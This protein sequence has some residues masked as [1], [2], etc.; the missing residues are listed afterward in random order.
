MDVTGIMA[1][2]NSRQP[3]AEAASALIDGVQF[4]PGVSKN[5]GVVVAQFINGFDDIQDA[6]AKRFQWKTSSLV[7]GHAA[8]GFQLATLVVSAMLA[9]GVVISTA[10]TD[11]FRHLLDSNSALIA[12]VAGLNVFPALACLFCGVS[13]TMEHNRD[14]S[15]SVK[16]RNR[17]H[18]VVLAALVLALQ[19]WL[20]V[21]ISPL[22]EAQWFAVGGLWGVMLD[23]VRRRAI[24]MQAQEHAID[25]TTITRD[26]SALPRPVLAGLAGIRPSPLRGLILS[27]TEPRVFIS[28]TRASG[29]SKGVASELYDACREKDIFCFLDE[30]EIS[31]GAYW[32]SEL[33][34][35]I[36]RCNVFVAILAQETYTKPWPAA[37]L[38]AALA[39]AH[40]VGHPAVIVLI[41][42]DSDMGHPCTVGRERLPVFEALV[43][44]QSR[45]GLKLKS[46]GDEDQRENAI[47]NLVRQLE[48]GRFR[49]NHST[50]GRALENGMRF[51]GFLPLA[52]M[53]LVGS[54]GTIVAWLAMLLVVVQAIG[55]LDVGSI[56]R[57]HG[58]LTPALMLC[59]FWA[60]FVGRLA[61][62]SR[63]EVSWDD[64][65]HRPR[66][67][68][69]AIMALSFIAV[70]VP[71]LPTVP[72]IV[73]GWATIAYGL[74][75][76]S[77][78][79]FVTQILR[80][81]SSIRRPS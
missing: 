2:A 1:L 61:L 20:L 50:F 8:R 74:G 25:C 55:W 44:Q 64:R 56:L 79:N 39:R 37:E 23:V 62:A 15:A 58:A 26:L 47:R 36:G 75:W 16:Q 5:P 12:V 19:L 18:I 29:W 49:S 73:L 10:W 28:Y 81:K 65:L 21:V 60:G 45:I 48:P 59:G 32:R 40:Q 67:S 35:A 72:A 77:G 53:L 70:T 9:V 69:H 78:V 17:I 22:G 31:K 4:G 43:A 42:A 33:N 52:I 80:M 68:L 63:F 46:V 11:T 71:W 57:S 66:A 7:A 76:F 30:L 3:G 38:E 34:R 51:L 27:D 14:D 54:Q 24:A 13:E 41:K 6:A